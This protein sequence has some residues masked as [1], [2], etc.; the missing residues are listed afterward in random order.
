MELPRH[1]KRI[2]PGDIIEVLSG[3]HRGNRFYVEYGHENLDEELKDNLEKGYSNH[4]SYSISVINSLKT[5][6]SESILHL[7]RDQYI[8][9]KSPIKNKIKRIWKS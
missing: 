2:Y 1:F 7:N 9:W 5:C 3:E 6:H 8:L 4:Y